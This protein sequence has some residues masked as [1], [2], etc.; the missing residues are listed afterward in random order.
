MTDV[1][2]NKSPTSAATVASDDA[3]SKTPAESVNLD[4]AGPFAELKALNDEGRH[5]RAQVATA[6]QALTD[7]NKKFHGRLQK[8][9]SSHAATLA[10][11]L[12]GLDPS[13]V[14]K[15][16]SELSFQIKQLLQPKKTAGADTDSED[17]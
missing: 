10:T 14:E 12:A 9:I 15:F 2:S 5:L 11:Q 17:E 6:Q 3:K 8:I 1:K 13:T 4:W 7:F 16:Q